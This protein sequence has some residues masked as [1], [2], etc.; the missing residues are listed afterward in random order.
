MYFHIIPQ[1]NL[2]LHMMFIATMYDVCD[3][4]RIRCIEHI[5]RYTLWIWLGQWPFSSWWM[6]ITITNFWLYVCRRVECETR[7]RVAF[8]HSQITTHTHTDTDKWY[9]RTAQCEQSQNGTFSYRTKCPSPTTLVS[10]HCTHSH[11]MVIQSH[12][13]AKSIKMKNFYLIDYN[14]YK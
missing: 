5:R 11:D 9:A 6:N 13:P 4:L 3:S 10:P 12:M 14:K 8:A 7:A 2:I 1:L